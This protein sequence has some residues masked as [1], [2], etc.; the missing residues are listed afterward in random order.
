MTA[1]GDSQILST[2]SKEQILSNHKEYRKQLQSQKI[3][4]S[5]RR[6]MVIEYFNTKNKLPDRTLEKSDLTQTLKSKAIVNLAGALVANILTTRES[7]QFNTNLYNASNLIFN[8]TNENNVFQE[9]YFGSFDNSDFKRSPEKF[10][11]MQERGVKISLEK[12]PSFLS[13]KSSIARRGNGKN[14]IKSVDTS[15][16]IGLKVQGYLPRGSVDENMSFLTEI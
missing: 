14:E 15:K 7:K 2:L 9:N 6:R 3:Y 5:S 8:K 12:N 11:T 13:T 16:M 4:I 1:T 10:N